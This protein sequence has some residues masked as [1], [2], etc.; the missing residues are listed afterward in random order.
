MELDNRKKDGQKSREDQELPN[1]QLVEKAH[2]LNNLPNS[3]RFQESHPSPRNRMG[4]LN[5]NLDLDR[6]NLE[7]SQ[8]KVE[9]EPCLERKPS[10]N[11]RHPLQN[12]LRE[13]ISRIDPNI[14]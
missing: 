6:V 10:P 9:N 5:G 8:G 3:D 2:M 13:C 1:L 12:N 4:N 11:Q 14:I 7:S